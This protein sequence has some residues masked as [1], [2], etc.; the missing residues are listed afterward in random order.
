MNFARIHICKILQVTNFNDYS[1]VPMGARTL[2]ITAFRALSIMD[3]RDLG[4]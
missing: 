3:A 1:A 2:N 4:Y